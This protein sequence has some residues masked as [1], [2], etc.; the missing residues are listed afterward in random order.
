VAKILKFIIFIIIIIFPFGQL[1]KIPLGM[2][3]VNLYLQDL[4][5]SLLV[6]FWLFW[7]LLIRKPFLKTPLSLPIFS[8]IGVT[9]FSLAVNFGYLGSLGFLGSLACFLYLFRWA[10]YAGLYFV[11]YELTRDTLLKLL[12]LA[13]LLVAILGLL[14]YS[15]YP[16]LRNLDYLGWDPHQNRLFGTFF[17]PGFTGIILVLTMMLL[18]C[19]D[20]HITR[21]PEFS[22]GSINKG[23]LNQ[24]Q[25]DIGVVLVFLALLFTYSRSSYLALTG[26]MIVLAWL[27]KSVKYLIFPLLAFLFIGVN[28]FWFPS[29]SEGMKLERTSTIQ[30]RW[31]NYKQSFKIIGDHPFFGVG[32]NTLRFVKKDYGF[33]ENDWQE[34]HSGAGLDNSLLFVWATTGIVGLGVY[35]WMWWKTAQNSKLKAQSYNLKVKT[36]KNQRQR[37]NFNFCL[38]SS[39]IVLFIH[40]FFL[41][42]LFYPWVMV[43]MWVL[44]GVNYHSL[45][46]YK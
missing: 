40:S 6:F 20:L 16:N 38:L 42:S 25:N 43:W 30:A 37:K 10:I 26:G 34:M 2:A 39:I 7:H 29:V 19:Q 36:K 17:D 32:F 15:F 23:I 44:L 3:G 41:N 1:T 31:E 33:L 18:L 8:F 45:E 46:E 4:V 35:L 11:I 27:R 5:I 13:G 24:V 28:C 21:H 22:S 9:F 12:S 14:Q